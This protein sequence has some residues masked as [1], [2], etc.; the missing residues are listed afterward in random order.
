MPPLKLPPLTVGVVRALAVRVAGMA[1]ALLLYVVL[2]RSLAVA[3]FG[4]YA[5]VLGWL[6]LL[7]MFATAGTANTTLRFLPQYSV[8][9][10]F[11]L[12]SGYLR[13]VMR[14]TL[15]VALPLTALAIGFVYLRFDARTASA[16]AVMLLAIPLVALI[17][18]R[19]A[20]L[21]VSGSIVFALLPE[22]V[23]RPLATVGLVCVF[24]LLWAPPDALQAALALLLAT[25]LSYVVGLRLLARVPLPWSGAAPVYDRPVWLRATIQL[26]MFSWLYALLR[27]QDL[28]LVGAL[29]D[30]KSAAH[31]AVA[32]RCADIALFVPLAMDVLVT[33]LVSERHAQGDRMALALLVRR[34]ARLAP[35]L[36]LPV[37]FALAAISP[38][39]LP[40]FGDAYIAALSALLVLIAGQALAVCTGY[41]A[42]L[43]TMTGHERVALW[44]LLAAIGVHL[45]LC[46]LLIPRFGLIGAALAC[47]AGSLIWRLGA[48]FAA[49]RMLGVNGLPFGPL[50]RN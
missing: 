19:Q 30:A 20:T 15:A 41:G 9:G 43:L 25:L 10:E 48:A 31:Y 7:A 1:S 14:L 45:L 6:N 27:Q 12:A 13:Y 18:Q 36:T 29:L 17:A 4:I 33:P 35:L 11:G 22:Q 49:W 44:I 32:L 28:L 38:W 46:V 42:Y 24:G 23:I 50:L 34:S 16:A 47:S 39:L 40:L 5:L 8:R 2:A 26:G 37:A 3:E 21:R